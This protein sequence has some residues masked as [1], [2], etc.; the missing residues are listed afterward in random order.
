MDEKKMQSFPPA[1]FYSWVREVTCLNSLFFP[2]HLL[3]RSFLCRL[4][5]ENQC[6]CNAFVIKWEKK[7]YMAASLISIFVASSRIYIE[8]LAHYCSVCLLFLILSA[9]FFSSLQ[10]LH[11]VPSSPP[12]LPLSTFSSNRSF[13]PAASAQHLTAG[14]PLVRA[15]TDT[16]THTTLADLVL[17]ACTCGDLWASDQD[18]DA[19]RVQKKNNKKMWHHVSLNEARMLLTDTNE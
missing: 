5:G 2:P 3:Y 11:S 9:T 16:H 4:W 14:N 19:V 12:S 17:S 6:I 18:F 8:I 10:S 7:R 13:L 15:H 1:G